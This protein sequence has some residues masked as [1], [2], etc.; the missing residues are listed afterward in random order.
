MHDSV[1]FLLLLFF[2]RGCLTEL[3]H[4]DVHIFT[5]REILILRS[6]EQARNKSGDFLDAS[7]RITQD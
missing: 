3:P 2:L 6:S 4:Y 5:M 1:S 7:V